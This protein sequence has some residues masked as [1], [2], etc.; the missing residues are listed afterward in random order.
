MKRYFPASLGI[1]LAVDDTLFPSGQPEHSI[2][3]II[4]NG[5]NRS[6]FIKTPP[7]NNKIILT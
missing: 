5:I 4:I 3:I 1:A 7:K 2:D 6:I